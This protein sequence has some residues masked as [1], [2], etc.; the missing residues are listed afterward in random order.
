MVD[1]QQFWTES[2]LSL[3][4]PFSINKPRVPVI[5]SVD[6]H[7]LLEAMH[8]E[9]TVRF[10]SDADYRARVQRQCNRDTEVALGRAFFPEEVFA[11]PP[12]RIEEVFGATQVLTEGG[13]PWLEPGITTIEELVALLR[14]VEHLDLAESVF[15][16]E[17]EAEADCWRDAGRPVPVLGT[18]IRGPATVGTS[19]CGTMN[20]LHWALDYPE[21][22]R[23]F[24]SLLAVRAGDYLRLVRARTGAPATGLKILD[25]NC[26]LLSPHLYER[27][28]YPVLR[29]LFDEFS[30]RPAAAGGDERYQHSDSAM[31]HLLPFFRE[32][33]MTALNLGPTI[34]P[35][36]IRLGVPTAVV[37]GQVPPATLADGTR[38]EIRAAVQ[39]D[40]E[41]IGADG[42]M[43]L[44]TAGSVRAGT[45][46][47]HILWFLAAA[48]E[49]G[50]YH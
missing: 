33:R 48:D 44:T 4:Q 19:V 2:D 18:S 7:W 45:T 1:L 5:V 37:H 39:R 11:H 30:P 25:D 20:Y 28:G 35:L 23:D 21:I 43:V 3:A 26:C 15:P 17:Y 14:H 29:A 50:R 40:I 36:T 13:T 10:Y 42:G 41:A 31:A 9:S 47:E 46:I 34:H 27:L 16:D 8:V 12:K 49:F 22:M 24:A 38:D 32:L 6:D